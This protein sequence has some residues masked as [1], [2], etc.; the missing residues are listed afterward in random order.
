[1]MVFILTQ[2]YPSAADDALIHKVCSNLGDTASFCVTL[3]KSDPLSSSADAV[4]LAKIALSN[5]SQHS[6]SAMDL[7]NNITTCTPAATPALGPSNSAHPDQSNCEMRFQDTVDIAPVMSKGLDQKYYDSVISD[8]FYL[9]ATTEMC[10]QELS[11]HKCH[12]YSPLVE[13]NNRWNTLLQVCL[14]LVQT[15]AGRV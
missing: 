9:R 14:G 5:F 6:Q 7:L 11:Q 8:L 15:L 12:E 3:L 2:P 1:M 4:G 10:D 13:M